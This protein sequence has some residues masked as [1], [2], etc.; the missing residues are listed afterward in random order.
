MYIPNSEQFDEHGNVTHFGV[1]DPMTGVPTMIPHI[2]G[3]YSQIRAMSQPMTLQNSPNGSAGSTLDDD[4]VPGVTGVNPANLPKVTEKATQ[5]ARVGINNS[6][7]PINQ[8]IVN[9]ASPSGSSIT[10]PSL[11]KDERNKA[12]NTSD[13]QSGVPTDPYSAP[14][15]KLPDMV[16]TTSGSSQ[17]RLDPKELAKQRELIG[18]SADAAIAEGTAKIAESNAR[19]A[20]H[21]ALAAEYDKQVQERQ[22][23]IDHEQKITDNKF[24]ELNTLTD[25][26]QN[27]KIDTKRYFAQQS[28]G[29][30]ILS[31]IALSLGAMGQAFAGPDG[32]NAALEMINKAVDQD[33][34]AQ[35]TNLDKQGRVLQVKRGILEDVR[36]QF[37]DKMAAQDITKAAYLK[38]VAERY[39]AAAQ[40]AQNPI[41]EATARKNAA[42]LRAHAQQLTLDATKTE[43]KYQKQITPMGGKG[44]LT[45]LDSKNVDKLTQYDIER[46][47]LLEAKKNLQHLVDKN[48]GGVVSRS[49]ENWKTEKGLSTDPDYDKARSA[50]YEAGKVGYMRLT[51]SVRPPSSDQLQLFTKSYGNFEQDPKSVMAKIDEHLQTLERD[52]KAYSTNIKAKSPLARIDSGDDSAVHESSTLDNNED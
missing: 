3:N 18:K 44:D 13:N 9:A 29:E 33:I 40:S 1:I 16:S 38:G 46:D 45:K 42:D 6:N 27:A 11:L 52:K 30:K 35:K 31:V 15:L 12:G 41:I 10:S 39:E 20:G 23:E 32:K 14:D 8:A 25:K 36:G 47:R 2:G 49:F 51:G 22:A 43:V 50:L 34:D 26:Y 19:A 17:S 5:E 37:K 21:Q 4:V 28:T 48:E 24:N 7:S